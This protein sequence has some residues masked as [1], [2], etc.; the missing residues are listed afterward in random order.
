MQPTSTEVSAIRF[1]PSIKKL[2]EEVP[3]NPS[4]AVRYLGPVNHTEGNQ[5][6]RA[7]VGTAYIIETFSWSVVS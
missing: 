7:V 1:Y 6:R 5:E 3:D 2:N 4:V